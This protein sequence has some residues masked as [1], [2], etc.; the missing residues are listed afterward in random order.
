MGKH[1]Y[2]DAQCSG[3]KSRC[4]QLLLALLYHR[5]EV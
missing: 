4:N 5:K 1:V 3:C 2:V